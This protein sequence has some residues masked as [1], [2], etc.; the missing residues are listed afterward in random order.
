[1]KSVPF[2]RSVLV[3]IL[4]TSLAVGCA[5]KSGNDQ[6]YSGESDNC[7]AEFVSDYNTVV[8]KL[9]YAYTVQDVQNSSALVDEFKN[10]YE[11]VVCNAAFTA[12][13][14]LDPTEKAV[15]ADEIVAKWKSLIDE[16]LSQAKAPTN[17]AS[18][19]EVLSEIQ[20]EAISPMG[21]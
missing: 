16:V 10:K 4:F 8:L 12:E 1:M 5:K 3:A 13:D 14:K 7:S 21:N 19:R 11:G 17:D 15:S 18:A 20:E 6:A 2:F 9:K